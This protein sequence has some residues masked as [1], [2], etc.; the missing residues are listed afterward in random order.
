MSIVFF[1]IVVWIAAWALNV[2]LANGTASGTRLVKVIVPTLFGL[3][4]LLVW[5]MLVRGLNVPLVI[6]P[7]PSLVIDTMADNL[8][9]LWKDFVQTF[10]KGALR[11]Y[12]IG[13][14]AAIKF[15]TG[16]SPRLKKSNRST[17]NAVR[18]AALQPIR[19]PRRAPLRKVCTKSFHRIARL[20]AIVST[21]RELSLIHI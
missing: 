13:C 12:L 8:A 16:N 2:K 4:L 10:L 14:S 19:Y 17:R 20:S 3:T 15:P 7:P 11:G 1:S 18:I 5:E 6:L 21:T 9:I